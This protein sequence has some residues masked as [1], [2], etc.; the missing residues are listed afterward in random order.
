MHSASITV[1]DQVVME[2]SGESYKQA[3][4]QVASDFL[5]QWDAGKCDELMQH[6]DCLLKRLKAKTRKEQLVE[7]MSQE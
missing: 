6:C 3:T 2:A 7:Q 1:H 4:Q 5:D